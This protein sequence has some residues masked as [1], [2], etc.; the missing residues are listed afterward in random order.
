MRQ[1]FL[2]ILFFIV[3]NWLV[4]ALRRSGAHPASRSGTSAPGAG[5]GN[6]SGA[7]ATGTADGR[8]ASDARQLAAEPMIRCAECGVHAP[9]SDSVVVAGQPF[10]SADHAQRHTARHMGRD[11]R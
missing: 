1:I 11:A 9:Q 7:G 6:G 8:R 5:S 10:C 3:G 4:K 2:L